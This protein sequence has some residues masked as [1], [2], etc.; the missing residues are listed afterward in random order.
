[1]P[2]LYRTLCL[3]RLRI[4]ARAAELPEDSSTPVVVFC[5]KGKAESS[6]KVAEK[7]LESSS[8]MTVNAKRTCKI[9]GWSIVLEH[10]KKNMFG[11]VCGWRSWRI[12][13]Q[14]ILWR[15]ICGTS[16]VEWIFLLE[17]ADLLDSGTLSQFLNCLI[18]L[19][20]VWKN[21]KPL[22]IDELWWTND[23][24]CLWRIQL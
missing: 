5:A 13:L 18:F 6:R 11:I 4:E 23:Y 8:P 1:M 20:G 14:P 10:G 19:F 2:K 17:P 9:L 21:W 16:F 24:K 7:C 3:V 22:G 12:F 15:Q